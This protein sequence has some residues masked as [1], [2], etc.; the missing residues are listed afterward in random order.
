V[1]AR[2]AAHLILQ[3]VALLL[4][5]AFC[6]SILLVVNNSRQLS[7]VM[8]A[9][10]FAGTLNEYECRFLHSCVY[11]KIRFYNIGD[12]GRQGYVVM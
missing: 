4:L 12:E 9:S 6:N 11:R 2:V 5:P 10:G 3:P 7:D 1:L 8:G